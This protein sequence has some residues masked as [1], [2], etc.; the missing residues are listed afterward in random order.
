MNC[1]DYQIKEKIVNSHD[2]I[3]V[4]SF[5]EYVYNNPEPS[6]KD[7][8]NYATYFA[9]NDHLLDNLINTLDN[10]VKEYNF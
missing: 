2:D 7:L 5:V 8:Q 3:F 1:Q 9:Q 10:I 6:E 4:K